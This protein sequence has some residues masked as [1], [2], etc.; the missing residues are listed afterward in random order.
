MQAFAVVR[1]FIVM[2][3]IMDTVMANVMLIAAFMF[4]NLNSPG[5]REL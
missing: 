1:A 4:K 3:S 5:L 2:E